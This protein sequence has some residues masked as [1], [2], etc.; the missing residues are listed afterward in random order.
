MS[1]ARAKVA[2]AALVL[3]LS[4]LL[5]WQGCTGSSNTGGGGGGGGFSNLKH[6]VFIVKE[7]RTFD[8]YF[9]QFPGANGTT[10]GTLS[11]G[12]VITL[13]HTPDIMPYDLGHGWQDAHTAINGGAMN[14][15]DLVS[16]GN[17]NGQ[18]LGYT[19]F[20]SAD[21]PN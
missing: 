3:M 15:F 6:I 21:I 4:G 1:D 12:Q 2:L 17:K 20:T 10:K 18:F 19:Q 9:G 11:T 8:N 14:Q 7:N 5:L 16:D 13:G